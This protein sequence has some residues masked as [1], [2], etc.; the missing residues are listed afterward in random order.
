MLVT[1][2]QKLVIVLIILTGICAG[3]DI[4]VISGT[5]PVIKNELSLDFTQLSKIAGIVFFG[6]LLSKLVSGPLMDY[7][8]RKNVI[9]LGSFLF[10]IS[11]VLMIISGTYTTLMLSRLLQGISIG[12]LLTVIPVYISETSAAKFR[13][14]A[15]ATFQLSLVSGIFLA[16]FFAS[17]F[18]SYF[19]WRSI[20]ACAIPFA[21]FLFIISI[22]APFSPSWLI[23]KGRNEQALTISE[24]LS[25]KIQYSLTN[26]NKIGFVEFVKIV[27]KQKYYLSVALISLMAI[28][29]GFV[30]INVF[31][32]YGPTIFGQLGGCLE[33]NPTYYG[34]TMTLVNL[35]ATFFGLFLVD[36]IGR[37][38]LILSGLLISFLAIFCM[39]FLITN[40]SNMV[41]L[42]LL[43][44]V[45]FGGAVGPGV[46]IWLVLSEVL[47][48]QIRGMGISIAL[49]SK[50]L[51]ESMFISRFLDLVHNYG[52][53]PIL[54]FMGIC[55][56][57]FIIIV[58]KFLPEMTNK[59]LL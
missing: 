9:S 34:T 47:P 19:G 21:I 41:A 59:E 44:M 54:Y 1:K 39:I 8:S 50:A 43:I 26:K 37:R 27:I 29:N 3:F 51:I 52:Y 53:A 11:L 30:G 22:L 36:M 40:S 20:F 46:C 14:R 35:I 10:T 57:V 2:Y 23:L 5:L 45:V 16:N 25:L 4:G 32:S 42:Y 7:L 58:Y 6:A 49:V 12:F 33:C 55:I 48:V 13:G 24:Q 18:V 38:K 56:V 28:L 15:M 31:I 17:I